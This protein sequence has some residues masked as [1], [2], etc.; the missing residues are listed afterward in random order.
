[1]KSRDQPSM[2]MLTDEENLS[3]ATPIA[4]VTR[5]R[6]R[7]IFCGEDFF[8]THHHETTLATEKPTDLSFMF[9]LCVQQKFHQNSCKENV[10]PIVFQ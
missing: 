4:P 9:I 1:M 6:K 2:M 10:P 8:D 5:E 3:T 7:R